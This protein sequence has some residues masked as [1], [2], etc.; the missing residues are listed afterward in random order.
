MYNPSNE[1]PMNISNWV[2]GV[3][4]TTNISDSIMLNVEN[5][6]ICLGQ[7]SQIATI[8]LVRVHS[9]VGNAPHVLSRGKLP[10]PFVLD[11]CTQIWPYLWTYKSPCLCIIGYQRFDFFLLMFCT[12]KSVSNIITNWLAWVNLGDR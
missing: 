11:D 3:F 5:T 10:T 4:K 12:F 8:S 2:Q 7:C 6:L 1:S 9:T